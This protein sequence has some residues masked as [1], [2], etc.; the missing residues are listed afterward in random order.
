VIGPSN[1]AR[2]SKMLEIEITVAS[3]AMGRRPRVMWRESHEN[4]SSGAIAFPEY[5]HILFGCA[6]WRRYSR[7]T[8]S[9][10]PA[11]AGAHGTPEG[12]SP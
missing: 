5:Q 2:S 6:A 10:H 1:P 9:R 4:G 11:A 7:L 8:I 12:Q 3:I